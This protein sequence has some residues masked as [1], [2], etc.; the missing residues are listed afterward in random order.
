MGLEGS[1]EVKKSLYRTAEGLCTMYL[2]IGRMQPCVGKD[3][4][5]VSKRNHSMRTK[6]C[7][8]SI[9]TSSPSTHYLA[10]TQARTL[11]VLT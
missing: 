7:K 8:S 9:P 2:V 1:V 4:A 3:L 5:V 6:I 10:H 11:R